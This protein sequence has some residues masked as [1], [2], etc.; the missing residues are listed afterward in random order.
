[1]LGFSIFNLFLGGLVLL[2]YLVTF[3]ICIIFT[4][5]LDTY[6]KVEDK[7]NL[8]L[9]P[10]TIITPL[11]IQISWVDEWLM[12]YHRITGTILTLLSLIGLRLPF[13]IFNN[14]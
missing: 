10:V 4:V 13:F 2:I 14:L 5:S 7:L 6:I 1:M 11:D 8:N 12:R 3:I 9:F